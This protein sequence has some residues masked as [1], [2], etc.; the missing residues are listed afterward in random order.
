MDDQPAPTLHDTSKGGVTAAVPT[1]D[2]AKTRTR[3]VPEGWVSLDA[4]LAW[5]AFGTA[6]NLSGWN[7]HFYFG[8]FV[9]MEYDP[10][11]LLA[12]W[13]A[14]AEAPTQARDG[15][16]LS[17][18]MDEAV[19][20]FPQASSKNL[21]GITLGS[22]PPESLAAAA[23]SILA[24]TADKAQGRKMREEI[25]RASNDLRRA[26]ASS[27]LNAFGFPGQDPFDPERWPPKCPRERI[28]PDVCA[29]PVTL[30]QGGIWPFALGD[31]TGALGDEMETLWH[32][33]LIDAPEL[34]REF[35]A[36]D[37]DAPTV[38]YHLPPAKEPARKG[39]R[40]H[41]KR[42]ACIKEMMRRADLDGL[43]DRIDFTRAMIEWA[44]SEFDDAAPG[45]TTVRDLVSEFWPEG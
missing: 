14:I 4:A 9:W 7:R 5:V 43:V 16:A 35:P 18:A 6:V 2:A 19:R 10:E 41:V 15:L 24:G 17:M 40:P 27:A 11:I 25:W 42:N 32:E 12:D 20:M 36:P 38:S 37:D 44:A 8:A 1:A 23:R 45:D 31:I 34:L 13:R 29:A 22:V 28:P 39:R 21:Y 3:A 33:I 26:I 30:G